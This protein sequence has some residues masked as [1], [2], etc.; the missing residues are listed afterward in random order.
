MASGQWLETLLGLLEF[1]EFFE[2]I[3][4][5]GF[6][7][8]RNLPISLS[9]HFPIYLFLP[10]VP[11]HLPDQALGSKLTIE[12]WIDALATMVNIETLAALAA[13]PGLMFLTDS[14]RLPV[15]MVFTLH[16]SFPN[17]HSRLMLL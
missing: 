11:R 17:T 13:E 6:I 2:F 16:L 12:F 3:G 10:P 7:E 14:D 15:R 9:P 1:I 8:F 5:L 4:L